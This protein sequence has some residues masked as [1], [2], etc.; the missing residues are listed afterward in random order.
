M[1]KFLNKYNVIHAHT[2][3]SFKVVFIAYIANSLGIKFIFSSHGYLDDWSMT[4]SVLKK[5][6]FII[7]S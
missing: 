2:I 4:H 1:Y 7:Y 3:W 5:K 6:F